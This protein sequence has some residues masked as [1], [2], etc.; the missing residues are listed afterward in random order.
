VAALILQLG[1]KTDPTEYR[2]S[3]PWLFRLLADEGVQF[4][5]LGTFFEIYQLPDEY[6]HRLRREAEDQNVRIHSIFTAHRELGGFFNDEP[7]WEAVARRN[8]ERLIEVGALLG[9][10]SV[11]SNPGAVYRDRMDTKRRGIQCYLRHLKELA[12]FAHERG[13]PWLTIE[14]MSCL[15]EP[16]TVPQEIR[17][18]A[19]ELAEWCHTHA[20]TTA[21]IGYCTDIAHGYADEQGTICHDYLELLEV[22][23]PHLYE[24]HLKNTDER[25]SSTFGFGPADRQRG[26]VQ[27]EPVRQMLL[28]R[29]DSL[30]VHEL[31]G[32]LEIGGPKLGRDYSDRDLAR[33]LRESLAYLK[34]VWPT[35]A[36]KRESA[37][38]APLPR[39]AARNG[40]PVRVAPSV[41]C[42]DMGH[43]EAAV[44]RLEAA[45]ADMLHLDVA[46]GHFVPNLLL[47][48][49]VIRRLRVISGLPMDAHLMVANPDQYI[50]PLAKIGVEYVSVH[51][52]ACDHLDRVLTEIRQ[53]GMKA[54]VALNPATPLTAL[55]YVL[56]RLDFVLLMTVNTG[57]AGQ[58]LVAAAI[59]K[60]A[61]CR[62]FLADYDPAIPIMVDG[63]VS[64]EHIPNMV[65]A[66]ADILVAGT[67]SWFDAGGSLTENVRKTEE[68]IAAG[69]KMRK[70]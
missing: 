56:E 50:E 26:I 37:G 64:F 12:E 54:G 40:R 27:I 61:D 51:A 68:A 34:E 55:Q 15:A 24:L 7:G 66:G 65:A 45:R 29:A 63:N 16:P 62:R 38:P 22:T 11:G 48:L 25:Y 14:P 23:L 13:V 59:R 46:D 6:F 20:D 60:I 3:Y 32:Y 42:V 35:D 30:P 8:F 47:G 17:Q 31:V 21:R 33:Q 18:M 67:S 70:P 5:Q 58:K 41:M 10:Q 9:V 2:F 49:D 36:T 69:L 44:C 39:Q 19:D 4:V 1:V 53:H 28:A 57:F 43:I 52:E